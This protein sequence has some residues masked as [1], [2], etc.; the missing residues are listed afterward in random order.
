MKTFRTE[1]GLSLAYDDVGDGLP[2]LC[3]AGLTRNMAD[4]GPVVDRFAS[5]ARIIRMDYRGRGA[6]DHADPETYSL[7]QEGQDALALLDRLGVDRAAILGTSRGGLIAMLLAATAKNRLAG[8]LLNDIGPVI[9]PVGI[10]F[11]MTYLGRRPA[12]ADYD[13]A[14]EALSVNMADGF[15]GMTL[16]QWRAAARRWWRQEA[17]G[18]DLL[19]DPALREAVIAQS[20]ATGGADL[21]PLFDALDGLPLGLIRGA[22]SNLLSR[23]TVAEMRRRR[24]DM[25]F[26]EVPDRGHVPFLDEPE[27]VVLIEE[28]LEGLQ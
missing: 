1:D 12:F 16:D 28:F 7:M 27:A 15:P 18:L 6:S 23:E 10:E 19:Y 22:N 3:L 13:A 8:V 17:D 9:E 4:F 26:S 25:R 5:Q 20:E 2:L 21:W 11:I 24:P 14:A